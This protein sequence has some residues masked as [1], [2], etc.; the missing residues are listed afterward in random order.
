MNQD[1]FL[2]PRTLDAPPLFFIWEADSAMIVIFLLIIGGVLNMFLLGALLAFV[3][4]KGYAQLKE[5]GGSKLMM[6]IMYWYTPS[7]VWLSKHAPSHVRE[8]IGG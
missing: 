7:D 3:I 2:I 5:E 6:K 1:D 4:G 8:F